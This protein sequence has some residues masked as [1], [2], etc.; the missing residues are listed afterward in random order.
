MRWLLIVMIWIPPY[1]GWAAPL[2][3]SA[4]VPSVVQ[5]A[6]MRLKLT[7][8][9]RKRMQAKVN[10]LIQAKKFFNQV[11]ERTHLFFPIIE[12]I[13]AKEGIPDDFKFLALHESML[14]GDVVSSTNDVGFWQIHPVTALDLKLPIGYPVDERM[15]LL[16]ST[17]AAARLLKGHYA[18]FNS[19][20]G[21]M[22]AY[23][24]G[25]AGVVKLGIK[26]YYTAKVVWLDHTTDHYIIAVLATKLAFE[27]VAGKQKHPLWQLHIYDQ[28]HH[29]HKLQD[30]AAYFN[31][32][33]KLLSEHNK[34]LKAAVVPYHTKCALVVPISHTHLL[35]HAAFTPPKQRIDLKKVVSPLALPQQ[36]TACTSI[37]Y[38]PRS[39]NIFPTIVPCHELRNPRFIKANGKLAIIAQKG[40]TVAT[41]AQLANL[42]VNRFLT[43]NDINKTDQPV[44]GM[45]Y[46][47]SEK[48][49]KGGA[50]YHVVEI[51]ESV[52]HVAQRYGIKLKMLLEKNRMR[53]PE[54][55]KV[56]QIVW[57]RFIRPRTIPIAYK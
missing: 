42:T 27:K 10:Q 46:Y 44:P 52:W 17:K 30:L 47:Y 41:L 2:S 32:E 56:G 6:G 29:G 16:Q 21:A 31:I 38:D 43:V 3:S 15:H 54:F 4:V 24:R 39:S 55:L 25:R 22:L 48:G 35:R 20:L 9:A 11:V 14:V 57:L 12:K 1:K 53:E 40:D 50:H 28:G 13:L 37:N 34:W 45:V 7:R 36:A 23:N 5:F 49:N 18:Y 26:Q 8:G 33:R 19:W 51:G